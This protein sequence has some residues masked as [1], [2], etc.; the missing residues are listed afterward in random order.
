MKTRPRDRRQSCACGSGRPSSR[1]CGR[2]RDAGGRA[3]LAAAPP[4][5]ASR[6]AVPLLAL[7]AGAVALALYWPTRSAPFVYDDVPYVR[8]NA[9]IQRTDRWLELWTL[10][11]PPSRP[12]LGLYRPVTATTYMADFARSGGAAPAFHATNVWLHAAASALAVLLVSQWGASRPAAAAAGV[13]FAVHPVHS[14]AVAWIVGRAEVLAAIG[15]MASALSWGWFRRRGRPAGLVLASVAY[16]LAL[17]AKETAAPL[18]AVLLLVEMLL[19]AGWLEGSGW[20]RLSRQPRA[21]LPYAGFAAA[22]AAYAW[23]RV[24]ALGSFS[25]VEA[26]TAFVGEPAS[27]RIVS[28]VAILGEYVRLCVLPVNLRVDY[29]DFKFASPMAAPV[30]SGGLA[31]AVL[32]AIAWRLRRRAPLVPL[33][34]GWLLLF[35]TVVSNLVVPIGAVLA[36]RFVYLPSLGACV[37]AGLGLTGLAP[38]HRA[39]VLRAAVLTLALMVAGGAAVLTIERNRDWSDPIRL[40]G[41]EVV[42]SPRSEKAWLNLAVERWA[43]ARSDDD[44]A[45]LAAAESAFQSGIALRTP[46]HRTLSGDQLRLVYFYG[47]YL[48][49]HGRTEDALPR[50]EQVAAWLETY[51]AMLG[52]VNPEFHVWFGAAL[53]HSGRLADARAQYEQAAGRRPGWVVPLRNIGQ[54]LLQQGRCDQAVDVYRRALAADAQFAIGYVNLGLCLSRLGRRTEALEVLEAL[55]RTVTDSADSAYYRGVL[56]EHLDLPRQAA[57]AYARTLELDPRRGDARKALAALER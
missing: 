8:D 10:P 12:E 32:A 43:R 9:S 11:Y 26:T 48:Q 47:N 27:T 25:M 5:P 54:L 50:Y 29:S 36:E 19:A 7:L 17:G 40:F 6:L 21:W 55:G 56:A 49:E 35:A 15:V 14:E 20:T 1:C 37:L 23:L 33:W 57:T 28:A 51:P 42:R 31:V 2:S 46:S 41:A 16:F 4:A 52:D 24:S 39:P 45:L 44:A 18:P 3:A 38:P 53:E 22:F 34:A 13:L 30:L